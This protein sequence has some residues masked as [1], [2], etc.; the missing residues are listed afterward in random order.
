MQRL[1]DAAGFAYTG[2]DARGSDL[3]FDKWRTR[4]AVS[5]MGVAVAPGRH[6]LASNKPAAATIAAELGGQVVLKPNRQGSSVGL[7]I[8]STKAGLEIAHACDFI[9]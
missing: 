7:Q 8:V 9:V 5:A 1:L 6:F 4:Q 2:C 3:C